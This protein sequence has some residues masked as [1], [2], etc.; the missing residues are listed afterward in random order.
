MDV[1]PIA[2]E[3]AQYSDFL[4]LEHDFGG[5]YQ[6]DMLDISGLWIL[7]QYYVAWHQIILFH[8]LSIFVILQDYRNLFGLDESPAIGEH[9]SDAIVG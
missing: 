3:L 5:E 1:F 8:D 9:H 4:R 7:V 6:A 2:A